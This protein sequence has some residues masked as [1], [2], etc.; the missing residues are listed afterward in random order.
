MLENDLVGALKECG[1][2]IPSGENEPPAYVEYDGDL[3][4]VNV[5]RQKQL[6]F[7]TR[8]KPRPLFGSVQAQ[9]GGADAAEEPA[10][11]QKKEPPAKTEAPAAPVPAGPDLLDKLRPLMRRSRGGWSG[12]VSFLFPRAQAQ[13]GRSQRRVCGARP[14]PARERQWRTGGPG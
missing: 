7:N 1:L 11:E 3:Y 6:F 10:P 2:A 14:A 9:R 8:E 13:R 12:S 5:N 4:W